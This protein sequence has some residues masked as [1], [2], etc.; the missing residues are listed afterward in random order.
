MRLQS[1]LLPIQA[2]E[3]K[4]SEKAK[5]KMISKKI[6]AGRRKAVKSPIV[7]EKSTIPIED[8]S[9]SRPGQP[10]EG[11]ES[12]PERGPNEL[13]A[14]TPTVVVNDP[15]TD[16]T[17]EVPVTDENESKT[18]SDST[19]LKRGRGR[20]AKATVLKKL[21]EESRYILEMGGKSK[22]EDFEAP[23]RENGRSRRKTA[24][25]TREKIAKAS[26]VQERPDEEIESAES[27]NEASKEDIVPAKKFRA[28][29]EHVEEEESTLIAETLKPL[30]PITDMD[31]SSL[32]QPAIVCE[33][34][35]PAS[36][37]GITKTIQPEK[38]LEIK[39]KTTE[40]RIREMSPELDDM[41]PVETIPA[42]ASR[43]EKTKKRGRHKK[44][45]TQ[46][47]KRKPK[48]RKDSKNR[49]NHAR[50]TESTLDELIE[51]V[52]RPEEACDEAEAGK[53]NL[54]LSAATR[55]EFDG[56]NVNQDDDD[57]DDDDNDEYDDDLDDKRSEDLTLEELAE[58]R[59][60]NQGSHHRHHRHRK[61]R[62]RKETAAE[63]P[64]DE[65][66]ECDAEIRSTA[67]S[68]ECFCALVA[69]TPA[70]S[71]E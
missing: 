48:V 6:A 39:A 65:D 8:D 52:I 58:R 1:P 40:E 30:S 57:D 24:L 69:R 14:T 32:T 34:D 47:E 28:D 42:P 68:D 37:V 15:A 64:N 11:G 70:V 53:E 17:K 60:R 66:G 41:F 19:S 2:K 7:A 18:A 29:F 20:P 63:D 59:A 10:P 61:H 35:V 67:S 9:V 46:T 50:V 4:P 31:S 25:E 26:K 45:K 5:S 44:V 36:F 23:S 22:P 56:D 21:L 43:V 54:E 38:R 13:T 33:D 51:S 27:A 49:R 3:K 71:Y 62:S 12:K 16:V 55:D